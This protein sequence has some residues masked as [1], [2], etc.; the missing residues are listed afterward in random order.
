MRIPRALREPVARTP[1]LGL[2]LFLT[3][4]VGLSRVYME[5][6]WPTDV[7]AGWAAGAVWAMVCW[8]TALWFE[9][10][11]VMDEPVSG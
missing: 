6:H 1:H 9:R 8:L 11:N 7:V 5:V 4:A 10:R 2:A 3:G